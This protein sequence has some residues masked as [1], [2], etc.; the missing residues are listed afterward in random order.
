[1]LVKMVEQIDALEIGSL[2]KVLSLLVMPL[3]F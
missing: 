2:E 3:N 1:M